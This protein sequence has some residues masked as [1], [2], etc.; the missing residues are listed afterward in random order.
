MVTSPRFSGTFKNFVPL[1]CCLGG[2]T[3]S[4][5]NAA[6]KPLV[7]PLVSQAVPFYEPLCQ[8]VFCCGEVCVFIVHEIEAQGAMF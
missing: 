7:I 5:P 4:S 6:R 1:K 3:Q 8:A 2:A